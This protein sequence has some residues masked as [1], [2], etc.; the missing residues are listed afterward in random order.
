MRGVENLNA[1]EFEAGDLV[2]V[3]DD[4]VVE[5]VDYYLAYDGQVIYELKYLHQKGNPISV[6][7]ESELLDGDCIN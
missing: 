7:S 6:L 2:D 4:G 5:V 3:G 1:L